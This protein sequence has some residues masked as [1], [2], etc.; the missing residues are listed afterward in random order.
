M[1]TSRQEQIMMKLEKLGFASR[2]QLQRMFSLGSN[3][4]AQRIL[5]SMSSYV[6][7]I[8]RGEYVYYLNKKGRDYVGSSVKR[9]KAENIEHALLRNEIYIMYDQPEVWKIE[10]PIEL[11]GEKY[12][13]P[14]VQFRANGTGFLLEVD[15]FQTML[16]NKQKIDKYAKIKS[17][18]PLLLWI[19][20]NENRKPK[21]E[22]YLKDKG[23]NHFVVTKKDLVL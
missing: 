21:L 19:I 6:N 22:Q 8:K 10:L 15:R 17:K 11:N 9:S 20:E 1:L 3:R 5:K 23:V 12:I 14:D 16:K 7:I 2:S 13:V 18:I 4:N